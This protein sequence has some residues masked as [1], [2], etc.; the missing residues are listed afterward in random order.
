MWRQ[1]FQC[2]KKMALVEMKKK[3]VRRKQ[4]WWILSMHLEFYEANQIILMMSNLKNVHT[5]L[6]LR[7]LAVVDFLLT[8]VFQCRAML[9]DDCNNSTNV[10]L[11]IRNQIEFG[12]L[13]LIQPNSW[14][15]CRS[16][17]QLLTNALH[18]YIYLLKVL[19]KKKY[20]NFTH[21]N[22]FSAFIRMIR[23]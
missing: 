6:L 13:I 18:R 17:S 19:S 20:V 15:S 10:S 2:E 12:L 11:L 22:D 5:L 7:T 1:T 8:L 23:A 21:L 4:S 16:P 9:Y 3:K 14:W